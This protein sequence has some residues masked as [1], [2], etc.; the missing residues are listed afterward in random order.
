MQAGFTSY[1]IF[2]LIDNYCY[3]QYVF[4]NLWDLSTVMDDIIYRNE[5]KII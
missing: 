4:V 5:M 1:E 3:V 2:V